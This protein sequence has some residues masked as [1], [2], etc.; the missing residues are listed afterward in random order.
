MKAARMLARCCVWQIDCSPGT[1]IALCRRTINHLQVWFNLHRVLAVT[2]FSLGVI[3][4]G[5]QLLPRLAVLE[6][7]LCQR[8]DCASCGRSIHLASHTMFLA[9]WDTMCKG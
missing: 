2:G 5:A 3:G 6:I 8:P 4:I 9:D 7:F 1:S